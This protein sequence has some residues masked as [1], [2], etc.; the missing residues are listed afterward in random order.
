MNCSSSIG[1]LGG[2][3]LIDLC[4]EDATKAPAPLLNTNSL[5]PDPAEDIFMY[6]CW[7][8][9]QY[10]CYYVIKFSVCACVQAARRWRCDEHTL[11]TV[12]HEYLWGV[13]VD[14]GLEKANEL[15][16]V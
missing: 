16:I 14:L 4:S 1:F 2:F 11:V 10:L 9:G 5:D 8:K 12:Q 15:W 6:Q 7:V 3:F 13:S